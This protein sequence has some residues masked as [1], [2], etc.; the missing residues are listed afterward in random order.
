MSAACLVVF[1]TTY[2]MILPAIT[3]NLD[4][5]DEEPG[6]EVEAQGELL[7]SNE[8]DSSYEDGTVHSDED[9]NAASDG[10]GSGE[11]DVFEDEG[12]ISAFF[13]GD[14][15]DGDEAF[16]S[17][18]EEEA[19]ENVTE[20]ETEQISEAEAAERLSVLTYRGKD[21][22]VQLTYGEEA[23]IP[24]SAE[25]RV[26]EI[27]EGSSSYDSYVTGAENALGMN[28]GNAGN[29][30]LFDI[31]IVDRNDPDVKYQ[32]ADGTR[33]DVKIEL[34]DKYAKSE[35]L[36]V[37]HFDDQ[38]G[39]GAVVDAEVNGQTVRYKTGGFSVF[40]I[41]WTSIEKKVLASDGHN[42]RVSVIY[43][44][45]AGIPEDAELEVSEVLPAGPDSADVS[46]P[47]GMSYEE[48]VECTENALG[49]QEGSAGYIRLF[50]IK[51]V[52]KD[53]HSVKYQPADGTTVDVRIE[54]ADMEDGK[55]LSVVHFADDAEQGN[56]IR[57]ETN[58]QA[59]SFLAEGF[60]VYSVV[61]RENTTDNTSLDG[62][63]YVLVTNNNALL[64]GQP[65]ASDNG[66]LAAV[67]ANPAAGGTL[68]VSGQVTMWTF[69]AVEGQPG[70][71]YISDGNGNYLN[72]TSTQGN[73]GTVT[74]GDR[75]PIYVA[76]KESGN[77]VSYQLRTSDVQNGSK[78]VNNYGNKVANGFGAWTSGNGNNEWFRLYTMEFLGDVR[79]SFNENGGNAAAPDAIWGLAG[80]TITLP[81]YTGTKNGCTFIGWSTGKNLANNTYY[82]VYPAGSE[83]TVPDKN[84]TLYA[85]W[86]ENTYAQ[87]KFY[88]RLD[89]TIPY[90]PDQYD[91]SAYT[92]AIDI[93]GAIKKRVWITDNDVNKPNNG[94][95][96]ENN[97]TAE[98]NQVPDITQLVNNINGSS[99]KLGFKVINDN[100]DIVVSDIT[101]PAVNSQ[102]YNVSKGDSLYVLWYVQKYAGKWHVDGSLLVKN[103][104]NIA[105]D[106]NAPDGSVRK[107]PLG[108]QESIGTEV[109][110]GASGSK[111]G[112]LKTPERP[113]YIFLG[114]NLRPDGSGT[115]YANGDP[116]TLNEDTTLYA[117]WSKGTNMM[118][119]SKT[120]EDGETLAGA[121]FKLEEKTASGTFIEKA[122]RTTGANGTFT[123]D[124]MENDTLYRM[125]E[126]YAPN[127]YEIQN[128]FYFKVA[129]DDSSSTTLHLHVCGEN[130]N[131][132]TEDE[133]P[134]WLNIEYIPAD[135]PQAQGV[136]RIRFNIR[137]ERIKRSITFIKVDEEGKPLSGAEYTL[138]NAK[139]ETVNNVLTNTSDSIGI[140]SVDD[141]V[142][143]YGSYTLTEDDA[144]TGY[145]AGDPVTFTLNDYVCADNTGLT[146][147]GG[148]AEAAC[149]VSS[150]T[151]QGLTIT[152]YAYT[153]T[154][155]DVEQPH[156]IVTKNIAVD[157]A[158]EPND[159]DTTIYYA[160]TKKGEEGYVRKENGDIWIETMEIRNGAPAPSQVVFDGVDFGDY[161]VWEMALIN[162]EYTRMYNGLVVSDHFQLDS[163][164]AS[165]ADG[166]NNANVSAN[167][168]EAQVD[169]TNH[170]GL[171]SESVSFDANKKWTDRAGN[172]IA[173]P[174]GAVIE[175]TVYSVAPDG[176]EKAVRSIELDGTKDPDGETDP[177]RATFKYLPVTDDDGNALSYKVKETRT[178]EGYYPN[179]Y[180]GEYYLTSSGGTIKNRKL[181]ADIELHKHFEIYP[182]N[183]DLLSSAQDLAFTVTLPDGTQASYPLADFTAS[184]EDPYDYVK[185]LTDQPLGEYSFAE[186]G[187][188]S[189]FR[190]AGY[191]LVYS[192]SSAD[193]EAK[194][195]GTEQPVLKLE[196]ENSYAKSGS[197][198]VKKNSIIYEAVDEAAVPAE[199]AGKSFGFVVKRG[200]LYL[201]ENGTLGTLPYQFQ[202][203]EGKSKEF[204]NVPAG[205]YTVIEQDASAEG[206]EWE[207]VDGTRNDDGSYSKSLTIDDGN[208]AG[209]ASFDNRYTKIENA[210]LT[211]IKEVVGGP[212][213]AGTKEY[214]VAIKTTRHGRTMWLDAEGN[215]TEEQTFLSIT[216]DQPLTFPMIPAGEYTITEDEEDA[217]FEEFTL[218][219]TCSTGN[220]PFTIHKDEHVSVTFTNTYDYLY[221]P[222]RITKTVT[223][224]MGD[225][226]LYFGFDVYVTDQEGQPIPVE[227]VTDANGLIQFSIKDG[228]DKL[229]EK[230][231]QGARLRIVEHNAHYETTVTGF[232]GVN[233]SAPGEAL[234]GTLSDS[235]S[236]TDTTAVYTITIP[237]N[238]ATIQFTN[239]RTVEQKVILKK[240]GF[241]NRDSSMWNLA[242]A[243]FRIYEDEAKT[244][245]VE[246]DGKTEFPSG[247]DGVFYAGKLDAGTYY[248]EEVNIP[249]GYMAPQG[250]LILR[251]DEN[252]VSLGSTAV[253]G[254]PDLSDW[255]SSETRTPETEGEETEP[256]GEEKMYTVS[257]RNTIGVELPSTGGP[258]TRRIWFPGIL[259]AGIAGAGLLVKRFTSHCQED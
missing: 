189:L 30:R 65:L 193:G 91:S 149:S 179:N 159:L 192:V 48:Y 125:T 104:V 180:P 217:A 50:D 225:K 161:D 41:V 191:T 112:T 79:V 69:E 198:I 67:S 160:L 252:G 228:E 190:D 243:V 51:I 118:T 62:N 182:E 163:V 223:G 77:A 229:F 102:N 153:V 19:V 145:A 114:W 88:I 94:L 107:V 86:N 14:I 157:G 158:L 240:T 105:Y 119:V 256:A 78:A 103:K 84:T 29:I 136:A 253:I 247:E 239:D 241:D 140:F 80:D 4:Q 68:Q 236:G 124:Q 220:D 255:I 40:A 96:I 11:Q 213:E 61:S 37:V 117:Q 43:G 33:V 173:A 164:A 258:G 46:V 216:R 156:I 59:V 249:D 195:G 146:I 71:Y 2:F 131:F 5:A 137:D 251:V 194:A 121:Q 176:T 7:S 54:L 248:L 202:L 74:L 259:L 126:T 9:A 181:T 139:G 214:Q 128:S 224:N 130:G 184:A 56:V 148:N 113:G 210:S 204:S 106:G 185:I 98:L 12:D 138:T 177:W 22:T 57:S 162:G 17:D 32:P 116:Y 199:I 233:A 134:D 44:P 34:A 231:P 215:L 64:M 167:D 85:V 36:D 111:N 52:D 212:A 168:L 115:G 169:F 73:E 196:L 39:A 250:M 147:T 197:L 49:M 154:V 187:Q 209:E 127:G 238:G 38:N 31:E 166:G 18:T 28:A 206:Y 254:Q 129:V 143:P 95:Y 23:E 58:G 201:Q 55:D 15:S 246:L 234:T 230:L 200:G 75:Q 76:A 144:P 8:G 89:G 142:L 81:D 42:Y 6:F 99:S 141:A 63:T 70:W 26:E 150:V 152:T 72:I 25:L 257:I 132:L 45:E 205:Q 183:T 66:K 218:H 35:E 175:F 3:I 208:A 227:G 188:E 244:K 207:V 100:R 47:H 235:V 60:S 133:K 186:T 10:S 211:V 93:T 226:E 245:P 53:D 178:V 92:S 135:D 170:Y 203:A 122:N 165:S 97:V 242:G 82:P 172:E 109:T 87:G 27:R 222:V 171:I 232:A 90:E 123:Y 83:F 110:I 120:N 1:M 219:V 221:A 237:D 24:E 174:D 151:D 20:D 155:K 108:Y 21:Y 16:F 13:G 101:N